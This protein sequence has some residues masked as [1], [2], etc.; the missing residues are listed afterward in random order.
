MGQGQEANAE[1][2]LDRFSEQGGWVFLQNVHLMQ[3]E[4]DPQPTPTPTPT[5]TP[6]P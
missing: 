3:T 2:C 6:N 4:P 5:P 1:A